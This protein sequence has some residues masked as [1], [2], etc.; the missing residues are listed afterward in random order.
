MH[1]SV[2]RMFAWPAAAAVA[3]SDTCIAVHTGNGRDLRRASAAQ[4]VHVALDT[5]IRQ[6]KQAAVARYVYTHLRAS[7]RSEG[8]LTS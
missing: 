1:A 8:R 7:K 4:R 6:A 2:Q 5:C 3:V